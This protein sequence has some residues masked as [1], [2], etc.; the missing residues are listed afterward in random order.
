MGRRGGGRQL[1][2]FGDSKSFLFP[3]D[4]LLANGYELGGWIT[5]DDTNNLADWE[6][7]EHA[8]AGG[9][10]PGSFSFSRFF[11]PLLISVKVV[12]KRNILLSEIYLIV[13][14]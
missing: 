9:Q 14:S 12:G 2:C 11:P 13:E 6:E 10:G 8:G 3:Q 4:L 1:C 5:G 7:R